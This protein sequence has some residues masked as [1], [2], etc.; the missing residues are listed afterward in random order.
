MYNRFFFTL[1]LEM[2]LCPFSIHFKVAAETDFSSNLEL[3][4]T[5]GLRIQQPVLSLLVKRPAWHTDPTVSAMT[6]SRMAIDAISTEITA[7]LVTPTK[8]LV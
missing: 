2:T 6:G 7:T 8:E 5:E 3:L 1:T 4:S